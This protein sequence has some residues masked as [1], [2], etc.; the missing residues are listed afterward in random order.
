MGTVPEDVERKLRGK[1]L[2]TIDGIETVEAPWEHI[3]ACG[4]YYHN[5]RISGQKKRARMGCP[6]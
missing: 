2:D 4:K 6:M 5:I 3:I 1:N